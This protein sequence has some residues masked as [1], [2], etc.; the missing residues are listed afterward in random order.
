MT[1]DSPAHERGLAAAF[2][3]IFV[4]TSLTHGSLWLSTESHFST[5]MA[6]LIFAAHGNRRKT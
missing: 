6:A 5:L 2:T 4:V 1:R 3:G